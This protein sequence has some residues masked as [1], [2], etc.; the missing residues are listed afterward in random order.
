MELSSGD[1]GVCIGGDTGE[2]CT[3]SD[4]KIVK[5]HKQHQCEECGK[6][7]QVGEKYERLTSLYEGE[8][9][10]MEVCLI[11]REISIAFSCEGRIIGN[12]WEDIQD[13][14]FPQ[15]TTGCLEKLTT[16]A[17][18]QHLVNKWREWKF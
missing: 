6:V 10:R 14:M 12:M 4:A 1:C 5:A 16:A 13:N 18:K 7:I 9:S 8:W 15:M 3:L 17:A 2:Y 11:C